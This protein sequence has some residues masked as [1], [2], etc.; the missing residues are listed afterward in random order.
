M[1]IPLCERCVTLRRAANALQ[2]EHDTSDARACCADDFL[3]AG[4]GKLTAAILN[5]GLVA[6]LPGVASMIDSTLDS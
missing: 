5:Y 4:W 3:H 2:R 6:T 1:G